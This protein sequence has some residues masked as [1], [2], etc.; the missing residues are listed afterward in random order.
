M[1]EFEK[2]LIV[3]G[4]LNPSLTLD[5]ILANF[6]GNDLVRAAWSMVA[7]LSVFHKVEGLPS[8][9]DVEKDPAFY[10]RNIWEWRETV[11]AEEKRNRQAAQLAEG[12]AA[13]QAL[14]AIRTP[15]VHT[16]RFYSYQAIGY[17]RCLSAWND[18]N[19]TEAADVVERIENLGI[20]A[21]FGIN[22][23][24]T[25]KE[26]ISWEI[27]GDSR[28]VL[29]IDGMGQTKEYV[30]KHFDGEIQ[31]IMKVYGKPELIRKEVEEYQ[32]RYVMWWD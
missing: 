32:L 25:G 12:K 23:P 20:R 29:C 6:T 16:L 13:F 8:H 21:D 1:A 5:E 19:P 30:Q 26:V 17:I 22:N 11:L 2:Q 3:N 14:S 9:D 31:A 7:K 18:F 28:I 10:V 27:E 15:S 24:N 4:S